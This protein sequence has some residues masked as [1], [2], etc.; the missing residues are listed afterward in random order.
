MP[1]TRT[2]E[3]GVKPVP[4]MFN[5]S[6]VL[7]AGRL[8]GEMEP[9]PG[10]GLLTVNVSNTETRPPGFVTITYGFP[11]MAIALAGIEAVSWVEL[12]NVVETLFRLKLTCDTGTKPLPFTVRMNPTVPAIALAGIMF[13]TVGSVLADRI[14]RVKGVE[15]P[16]PDTPFAGFIT[17]M[18]AVPWVTTSAA[19]IRAVTCT[20][21]TYVVV[22]AVPLKFATE[23]VT[24]FEP[25]TVKVKSFPPAVTL[26]GVMDEMTGEGLNT[27]NSTDVEAPPPGSGLNTKT[28]PVPPLAISLARTSAFNCVELTNVVFRPCPPK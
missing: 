20:E 21:L 8:G 25:L 5:V 28:T 13:E 6:A 14:V 26:E 4:E 3:P 22:R 19:G 10:C 15:V 27:V 2:T 24:K 11:A 18:L 17:V 1:F 23:L 16:P 7:P 9:P 12:T